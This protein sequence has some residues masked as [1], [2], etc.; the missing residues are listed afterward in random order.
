MPR[1][2]ISEFKAKDILYTTL[3]VPFTGVTFD[4]NK[5]SLSDLSLLNSKKFVVKVDQGIKKR[6]KQGL[7]GLDLNS[8]EVKNKMEEFNKKG[9]DKFIIEE[10]ISENGAKD[11]FLSIQRVRVGLQFYYSD[12]GGVDIEEDKDSIR[13]KLVRNA[14]DLLEVKI[15]LGLNEGVLEKI[16]DTFENN[17]F[18]FLEINPLRIIGGK[19]YILDCAVE[20]DDAALFFV[21]NSWSKKDFV[22]FKKRKKTEEELEIEKL[23]EESASSFSLEVLNPDGSIFLLL[24]GGGGSVVLADEV[25]LQGEAGLIGNYGEYSGNPNRDETYVY[26]KNLLSLLL[27]SK[28]AKKVLIIGGGVANFTDVRVTFAGIIKALDETKARLGEQQVKVFVRRGGP[29]DK[30]GLASMREFLEVNNLLGEVFGAEIPLTDIIR[31]ALDY[32]S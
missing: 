9:Y 16:V 12:K 30:E 27:K 15:F 22:D 18:S 31:P 21:H 3:N 24:S 13:S 28:A 32:V 6:F 7:I 29:H 4:F 14:S 17:Y 5:N 23:S 1:K 8:D 25:F 11:Y 2:K 19:I 20:V 10:F 26:T